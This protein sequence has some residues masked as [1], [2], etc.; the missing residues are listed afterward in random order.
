VQFLFILFEYIMENLPIK[1]LNND[2]DKLM[3]YYLRLVFLQ[4]LMS[5]LELLILSYLKLVDY[6]KAHLVD[7]WKI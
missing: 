5:H 1:N 6:K 4:K 3:S 7:D 2:L